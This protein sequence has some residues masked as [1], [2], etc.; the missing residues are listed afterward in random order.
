MVAGALSLAAPGAAQPFLADEDESSVVWWTL[1]DSVSPADL[2][3][4]HTDPGTQVVRFENSEA[5]QQFTAA[6]GIEPPAGDGITY[7]FNPAEEPEHTPLWLAFNALGHKFAFGA[8]ESRRRLSKRGISRAGRLAIEL[9]VLRY[10]EES[11]R[12]SDELAEDSMAF[13]D[14]MRKKLRKAP[15]T[16]AR[17]RMTEAWHR[18][19]L[20]S[21]GFRHE[22]R[23]VGRKELERYHRAWMEVPL[24]SVASVVLPQLRS[25]LDD[26][27]WAKFREF[28][29][30]EVVPGIGSMMDTRSYD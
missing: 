28:L 14:F 5:M 26:A 2:R 1:S 21:R 17:A 18:G 22:G 16:A 10:R 23:R 24:T 30:A 29:L 15:N 7:Y 4:R 6:S 12:R 11:T 8:D 3:F 20:N 19:E 9:H 13:V 27:D 25:T